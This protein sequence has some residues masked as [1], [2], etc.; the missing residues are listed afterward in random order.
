MT[1]FWQAV[2]SAVRRDLFSVSLDSV[3]T[4]QA[5]TADQIAIQRELEQQQ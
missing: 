5:K 2:R 1:E 4:S 3:Y